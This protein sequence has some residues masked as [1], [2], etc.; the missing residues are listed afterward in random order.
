M[1]RSEALRKT[2]AHALV[3]AASSLYSTP[4]R[5][6]G[7]GAGKSA[8]AAR[9]NACATSAVTRIAFL[10]LAGANTAFSA[11]YYVNS[12]NGADSNTGLSPSA[13]WLT[14]GRVRQ[15]RLFAGDYVLLVR[16]GVW[17]EQLAVNASGADGAPVTFAAYGPGTAMPVID[18]ATVNV[19]QQS[20]LVT[21]SGRSWVTFDGLEIRNSM[22][23]GFMAYGAAN[24]ALRNCAVHGHQYNGV[25][26]FDSSGITVGN[27]ELYG[28]SLNTSASYAGITIDGD[29]NTPAGFGIFGNRIHDNV[30]GQGW[31]GA[32]GIC[33]GHTG[34]NIPTLSGI[35]IRGNQI[36][37]NGNPSQN[38]A[39]RG[40]SGSFNGDVTIVDNTVY[41]NASA[42]IY[43]GDVGLSPAIDIAQNV[44]YD[45]ALRQFGGYTTASA[46]A[47]RNL[48][49]VDDPTITAMG[50]E[51]GGLG[52][53]T[54]EQNTFIYTT[55]TTDPYRGFIRIN[56]PEQDALLLSNYNTFYSAGPNR[57][58][59]SS[60]VILTFAQWQAA[61]Y[62]ANSAN[63]R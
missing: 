26:V 56:N 27:C 61:G 49:L 8:D 16:G 17:Y 40:I 18:G 2:V 36:Y 58:I 41:R 53:W 19:P 29:N 63:P 10:L 5:A 45:N 43:L 52:P 3:R 22:R 35:E 11:V 32:N 6:G 39:R 46:M 4:L 48:L 28:N 20:A 30:G 23:D 57:W 15:S 25:I 44:F 33:L 62:D 51:I 37:D 1:A 50:A 13:A 12:Y 34:G 21:V 14:L 55:S 47:S 60:G 9:T 54:L 24:V 7:P 31:N 59:D 42:G 38:Q